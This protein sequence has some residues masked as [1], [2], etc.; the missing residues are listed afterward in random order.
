MADGS[1]PEPDS[2]VDAG[3]GEELDDRPRSLLLEII[4][5]LRVGMDLS[6][7]PL[8]TFILEPRSILEK[9]TDFL[10]HSDL[11]LRASEAEDPLQRLI[12]VTRWYLSGWHLRPKGV[13]KPYNPILGEVFRCKYEHGPKDGTT[14]C[15]AEQVSHHPPVSAFYV[16]NRKKGIVFH[17]NVCP[18]SRFLGNSAASLMEGQSFLRFLPHDEE[19]VMTWPNVYARGIII[20]SLLMEMGGKT[21]IRCEKSGYYTEIE[22]K[23][24]GFFGGKYNRVVGTIRHVDVDEDLYTIDGLWD[25]SFDITDAE[26]SE[27]EVLFNCEGAPVVP[28]IVLPEEK[29]VPYESRRLWAKVTKALL[30]NDQETATKFK[31]EL[32]DEQ[33]RQAKIREERGLRPRLRLFHEHGDGTWVYNKPLDRPYDP[34]QD[35]VVDIPSVPDEPFFDPPVIG[36]P[37]DGSAEPAAA[38]A[39]SSSGGAAPAKQRKQE[40]GGGKGGSGG[41]SGGSGGG[42]SGGGGGGGGG[43]GKG[44]GTATAPGTT[45]KSGKRKGEKRPEAPPDPVAIY[46]A[47]I[48]F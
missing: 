32:E 18:K 10:T 41:G 27:T 5:Q 42:G 48:A 24:K 8:P 26:T 17:G 39:T 35:A 6:R 19:Y 38:A 7:V 25:T 4:S 3:E 46:E 44:G 28:Q 23:T 40:A 36:V 30:A 43:D 15:V 13:K 47:S 9:L 12:G 21:Y 29:Q 33:R 20:G 16:E 14:V 37:A 31:A 11:L 22:F 1:S 34:K 45:A 2:P